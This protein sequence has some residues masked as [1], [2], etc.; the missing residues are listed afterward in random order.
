M[1]SL[2]G[3]DLQVY[4]QHWK[5]T[6]YLGGYRVKIDGDVETAV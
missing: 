6:R 2:L 1:L 5:Q 3:L 4:L